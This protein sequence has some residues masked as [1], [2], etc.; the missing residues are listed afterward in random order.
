MSV[1]NQGSPASFILSLTTAAIAAVIATVAL[2][3]GVLVERAA[4]GSVGGPSAPA[5]PSGEMRLP[6]GGQVIQVSDAISRPISTVD[7]NSA[8][9]WVETSAVI[10]AHGL[11]RIDPATNAVTTH[12]PNVFG[13]AFRG[14]ELWAMVGGRDTICC[15]SARLRQLNPTTG[16][17]LRTIGGIEGWGLAIA[18]DTA[19]TATKTSL[20]R[21]DLLSGVLVETVALPSEPWDDTLTV[22]EGAVWANSLE[23]LIRVDTSRTPAVA[24]LVLPDEPATFAAGGGFLWAI[25]RSG[26]EVVQMD[27][28]TGAVLAIIGLGGGE[29]TTRWGTLTYAEGYVWASVAGGLVRI[30]PATG[31]VGDVI[32]LPWGLYWGMQAVD[33]EMWVTVQDEAKLVRFPLPLD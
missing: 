33:G 3:T 25:L 12:I 27:E 15:S 30:D 22:T 17:I 29:T 1:T 10:G 18:G 28:A 21:V 19:W 9:V 20:L 11:S 5:A 31:S 16:A 24:A 23:G 14:D 7:A 4:P 6:A 32:P 13:A 26:D 2:G 8:S